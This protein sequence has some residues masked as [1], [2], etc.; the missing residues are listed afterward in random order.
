MFFA[1]QGDNFNGNKYALDALEKGCSYAIVDDENL[2]NSEGCIYVEDALKTMQDLAQ[3]HRKKL[4]IPIFAITGSNGK[5]TTKELIATILAQKYRVAATKGNLNNH[6][7]VPLTL[8]S[9]NNTIDFGV[10]EIG[11]S[12]LGEVALLSEICAPTYGLITNVGKAHIEGFGSLNG[13]KQAKGELYKYLEKNNGIVF[14]NTDSPDLKQMIGNY[15][16]ISYGSNSKS[17]CSGTITYKDM[18]IGVNWTCNGN[19]GLAMS[20][21][22]GIYNFENI[23]AAIAIGNYFEIAPSII[24]KTI[25]TYLPRNNR[26]QLIRGRRNQLILDYYNANPTSMEAA[27]N[28]FTDYRDVK[29]ALIIGDML[30]LGDDS[31]NEHKKILELIKQSGYQDVFIVGNIFSQFKELYPYEYFATAEKLAA[32]FLKTPISGRTFLIKG[33]RGIRLEK[34][35]DYL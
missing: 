9:M 33:S 20:N 5:T 13:V 18:Y 6:I 3:F 17:F 8:L 34:C 10:V 31:L 25:N 29:K 35:T 27:I 22:I 30:E 15:S 2:K 23:L 32:H 28:N 19:N 12:T 24:D 14:L 11:A 7:G 21:L 4:N 1:L 16:H 26:S